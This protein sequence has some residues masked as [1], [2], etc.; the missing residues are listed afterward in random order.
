VKPPRNS[1]NLFQKG[2]QRL[3]GRERGTKNAVTREVREAILLGLEIAGNR[4]G[5]FGMVSYI[6]EAALH[7]YKNGIAMLSLVTPRQIAATINTKTEISYPTL[8]ELNEDL[9]K[10]GLKPPPELFVA[11]WLGDDEVEVVENHVSDA[12]PK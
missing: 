1:P 11:D 3:G 10:R 7:D 8:A 12:G 2:H 4:L 6:V 9:R 5:R